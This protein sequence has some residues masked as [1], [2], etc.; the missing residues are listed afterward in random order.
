M[1]RRLSSTV[2][3]LTDE[4]ISSA[5]CHLALAELAVRKPPR[6]TSF[7]GG[8]SKYEW[9]IDDAA[10]PDVAHGEST[11]LTVIAS[12]R[13]ESVRLAVRA[14]ALSRRPLATFVQQLAPAET[15]WGR[16]AGEAAVPGWIDQWTQRITTGTDD[17]AHARH[18]RQIADVSKSAAALLCANGMQWTDAFLHL[19]TPWS[20]LAIT[21]PSDPH[22]YRMFTARTDLDPRVAGVLPRSFVD[23]VNETV[24]L[25]QSLEIVTTNGF[26]VLPNGDKV[27]LP[28]IACDM[29]TPIVASIPKID[30][31][32][33]ITEIRRLGGQ[34]LIQRATV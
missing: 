27:R 22:H 8:A 7:G 19:R 10:L 24:S 32:T 31:L 6:R 23:Y 34:L 9:E 4:S 17:V 21:D 1:G 16:Q 12:L 15:A 26:C 2:N 25:T 28:R 29:T 5:A 3:R 14:P 33:A 11:T 20:D 18:R 30:P 13:C